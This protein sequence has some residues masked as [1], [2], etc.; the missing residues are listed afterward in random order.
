MADPIDL[1]LS[2][3]S[4]LGIELIDKDNHFRD[5]DF[6]Y[7]MLSYR[8]QNNKVFHFLNDDDEK[9]EY[10]GLMSPISEVTVPHCVKTSVGIP[11]EAKWFGFIHPPTGLA[12]KINWMSYIDD[13]DGEV[14]IE[15]DNFDDN[16]MNIG[17]IDNDL[18]QGKKNEFGNIHEEEKD[19]TVAHIS[20]FGGFV[21]FNDFMESLS[22]SILTV[23]QTKILFKLV[24]PFSTHKC[25]IESCKV[26]SRL[27][28][29]PLAIFHEGGIVANAWVRPEESFQSK[30]STD[31]RP[32]K[33]GE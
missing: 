14:Q 23:K 20:V 30:C 1:Y 15:E 11:K 3:N 8:I 19:I 6:S 18:R 2:P 16:L 21:Y 9:H 27:Q 33:Y 4:R 26:E 32:T 22:I 5:P 13:D 17:G 31:Q 29:I 24:G 25:V 10:K 28:P 7:K 12:T